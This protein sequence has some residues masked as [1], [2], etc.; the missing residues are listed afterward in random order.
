MDSTTFILFQKVTLGLSLCTLFAARMTRAGPVGPSQSGTGVYLVSH[1]CFVVIAVW[2]VLGS[3]LWLKHRSTLL[4]FVSA[5]AIGLILAFAAKLARNTIA[6]R[7]K[8]PP[9]WD[10]G[11]FWTW[12]RVALTSRKV[13]DP[14]SNI[15]VGLLVAHDAIWR[16]QVLNV[17]FIYPPPTIWLYAPFGLFATFQSAAPWWYAANVLAL[18]FAIVALWSN[19]FRSHPLG[20]LATATLVL[21]FP[22]TV[23][24]L[25]H[26]QPVVIAL[27]FVALYAADRS[28]LRAGVWLGL[29][30]VI[31]PLAIVLFL[32]PLLKRRFRQLLVAVGTVAAATAGSILLLGWKNVA[33]Y[34]TNGPY[35]RYPPSMWLDPQDG[36]ESL[37][38]ALVRLAHETNPHQFMQE[39]LFLF[40]AA[41]LTTV[42]VILCWRVANDNDGITLSLLMAL[43]LLLFPPSALYYNDLLLI[44]LFV[45]WQRFFEKRP[46]A[47]ILFISAMYGFMVR[48]TA[49]N[50]LAPLSVW[51]V[52]AAVAAARLPARAFSQE[53][54]IHR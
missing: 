16:Q 39:P 9:K 12:G 51:V 20:L 41:V 35:H 47:V 17:A 30:F 42:T 3:L 29:A 49:F 18:A 13:Y 31:K 43:A 45:L 6:A 46:I 22:A 19:Y 25:Y 8:T 44:P 24:T 2:V 50:I 23:E 27:L 48:S 21:A 37:Y 54:P 28:P 1:I 33:P 4:L 38:V 7:I 26:G 34:F 15:K 40:S 11:I 53:M 14:A 52:F 5:C 36:N 32:E 10:I